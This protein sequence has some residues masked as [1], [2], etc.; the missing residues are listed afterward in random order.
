M[1][2]LVA[3]AGLRKGFT[4]KRFIAIPF[5]AIM[6]ILI[7]GCATRYSTLGTETEGEKTAQIIVA[8]P[9]KIMSVL[10]DVVEENFQGAHISMADTVSGKLLFN[11]IGN[12]PRGNVAVSITIKYVTGIT[13]KGEDVNGYSIDITSRGVGFNSSMF[14]GYA[15]SRINDALPKVMEEHGLSFTV[16]KNAK[17]ARL[18]RE[19]PKGREDKK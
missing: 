2:E 17:V 8:S 7:I 4:M 10:L 16:V 5:W 12:F 19:L 9:Q 1:N 18:E 11:Y 14:P 15:I 13:E 3:I 6:L